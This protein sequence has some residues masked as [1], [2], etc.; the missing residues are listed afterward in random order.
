MFTPSS[1]F[2]RLIVLDMVVFGLHISLELERIFSKWN[3]T[4]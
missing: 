4:E 3:Q 1:F 2:E